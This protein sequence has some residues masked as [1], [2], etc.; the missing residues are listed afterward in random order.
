M[1]AD[2][3]GEHL[4]LLRKLPH[5]ALGLVPVSVE[6]LSFEALFPC[7]GGRRCAAPIRFPAFREPDC[8]PELRKFRLSLLRL[9]FQPVS[10]CLRGVSLTISVLR[11]LCRCLKRRLLLREILP[12]C[13]RLKGYFFIKESFRGFKNGC[14]SPVNIRLEAPDVSVCLSPLLLGSLIYGFCGFHRLLIRNILSLYG[15][16][17]NILPVPEGPADRARRASVPLDLCAQL[18]GEDSRLPGDKT[19][20]NA[21]VGSHLLRGGQGRSLA[22]RSRLREALFAGADISKLLKKAAPAGKAHSHVF[23]LFGRRLALGDNSVDPVESLQL[24]F[25]LPY[26]GLRLFDGLCLCCNF[27]PRILRKGKA[28][29][30]R[31]PFLIQLVVERQLVF[32]LPDHAAQRFRPLFMLRI[33]VL[34]GPGGLSHRKELLKAPCQAFNSG[35]IVRKR[36]IRQFLLPDHRKRSVERRFRTGIRS[37]PRLKVSF[38]PLKLGEVFIFLLKLI[39]PAAQ[40]CRRALLPIQGIQRR[41]GSLRLR[42][43]LLRRSLLLPDQFFKVP[44]QV[45]VPGMKQK[46]LLSRELL[47]LD[48]KA[49]ERVLNLP[50]SFRPGTFQPHPGRLEKLRVVFVETVVK[51]IPEDLIFIIASGPEELVEL[52]LGQHDDLA[53]LVRIHT[54]KL[55]DPI[56]DRRGSLDRIL[57][58]LA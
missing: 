34:F 50:A 3:I 30:F 9:V 6:E 41:L 45:G 36:F 16:M 47:R 40:L 22:G 19:L 18:F 25:V 42:G 21:V 13:E 49:F 35:L 5:P 28:L 17:Q 48:K 52:P 12:G 31:G 46:F 15:K 58:G 53:E 8:L 4:L 44:A 14:L 26:I 20:V 43:E 32:D 11:I 37:L 7:P 56:R 23:R 54:E 1:P 2:R 27:L 38:L 33:S 55:L 51:K 10:P 39:E 57:A 24:L 29:T